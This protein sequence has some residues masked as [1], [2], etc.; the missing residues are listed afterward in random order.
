MEFAGVVKSA[1]RDGLQRFNG[2]ARA[3]DPRQHFR[4][5]D[6]RRIVF[7]DQVLAFEGEPADSVNRGEP[8]KLLKVLGVSSFFSLYRV[9]RKVIGSSPHVSGVEFQIIGNSN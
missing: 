3:A 2:N 7:D 4:F 1:R 8:R 9:F 5:V 6:A